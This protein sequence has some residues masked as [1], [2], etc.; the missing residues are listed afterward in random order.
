MMNRAFRAMAFWLA[1]LFGILG[2]CHWAALEA[3]AV[4]VSQ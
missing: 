1:L 3:G 4:E 2:V